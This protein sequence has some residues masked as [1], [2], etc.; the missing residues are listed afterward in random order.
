MF[1]KYGYLKGRKATSYPGFEEQLFGATYVKE[2]VV[3]SD[4]VIT[5]RGM[6]TAI[7]FALTLIE[8]LIGSAE[9]KQIGTS[10][11]FYE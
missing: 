2:P 6:G 4:Y 10:I 8:L 7:P 9:A 3:V 5:S 1:G 11:I